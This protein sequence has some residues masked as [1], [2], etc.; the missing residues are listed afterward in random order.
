MDKSARV[1]I[2][3]LFLEFLRMRAGTPQSL[4]GLDRAIVEVKFFTLNF[5]ANMRD[6]GADSPEL[7]ADLR[8]ISDE[9][10]E[11]MEASKE[12]FMPMPPLV[13]GDN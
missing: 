6:L 2:T 8:K 1:A 4:H 11:A 12:S 7:E 9:F 13:M 10:L 5:I 3:L